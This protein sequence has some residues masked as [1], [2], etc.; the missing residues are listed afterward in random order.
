M[1]TNEMSAIR[2]CCLSECLNTRSQQTQKQKL[3]QVLYLVIILGTGRPPEGLPRT[4]P[5]PG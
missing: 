5:S 3:L 1:Q 4:F 2:N